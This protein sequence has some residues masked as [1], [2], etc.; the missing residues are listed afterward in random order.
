[1]KGFILNKFRGDQTLLGNAMDWLQERTG[2]PTVAIIPMIQHALPEEDTLHYRSVFRERRI[3]I[4]LLVYPYASNL[5]EFDPLIHESGVNV[6]PIRDCIPLD[7]YHAVLLPGSK[8]TAASLHYLRQTGLA[9]E[10][11]R[12]ARQGIVVTGVCGG[13]QILGREILDP[14]RLE[15]GDC[16]GLGLLDLCTTLAPQKTTR[17]REVFWNGVPVH[18]YEIRHGQ[19]SAGPGAREHLG[20]DLGWEQGNVYG[21]YLHGVFE[22]TA[23]RQHFLRKLGWNA[24]ASEEWSAT[25]D[26]HLE[27]VARLIPESGWN[28]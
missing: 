19:T 24:T 25:L 10:I 1:V 28:I 15:S 14:H 20:E 4:A 21:I 26:A 8:N 9:A 16:L 17:Q 5:E 18:G 22:N 13:L 23:Y 2:I 12:A 3:N 27:R 6:V 11:S 7:D